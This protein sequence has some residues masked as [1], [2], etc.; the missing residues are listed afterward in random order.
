MSWARFSIEMPALIRFTFN[1]DST[2][3]VSLRDLRFET[4]S[5]ACQTEFRFT[6]TQLSRRF[7]PY[8]N[9]S[10]PLHAC[11]YCLGSSGA[12]LVHR[13]MTRWEIATESHK[14]EVELLPV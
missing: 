3:L 10:H 13:Q 12:R 11:S 7:A 6:I 9:N 1:S 4:C 2:T 8:I 5:T 14:I